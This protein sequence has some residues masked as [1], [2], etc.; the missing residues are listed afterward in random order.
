MLFANECAANRAAWYILLNMYMN[1]AAEATET[2]VEGLCQI[3]LIKQQ[4]RHSTNSVCQ[5]DETFHLLPS[6]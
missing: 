2:V 3:L 6:A 4:G 5:P 1:S